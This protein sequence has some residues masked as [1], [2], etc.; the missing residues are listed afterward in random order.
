MHEQKAAVHPVDLL[1]AQWIVLD[2]GLDES[3]VA[4][5]HQIAAGYAYLL[6]RGVNGIHHARVADPRRDPIS[7]PT[8]TASQVDHAITRLY[9][10]GFKKRRRIAVAELAEQCQPFRVS[11]PEVHA[12]ASGRH[13]EKPFLT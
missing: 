9:A 13:G 12:V 7:D 4:S 11:I 8:V 3:D 6:R 2:A 10:G 5:M 1:A